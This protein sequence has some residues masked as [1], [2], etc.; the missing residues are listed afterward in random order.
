MCT[1]IQSRLFEMAGTSLSIH[2]RGSRRQG[3]TDRQQAYL[4]FMG[5]KFATF[6][7]N[8]HASPTGALPFLLPTASDSPNESP[9]PSNK[10]QQW[11]LKK[12]SLREEPSNMRYQVYM[13]LLDHRIR[14]AW[15]RL[16]KSY[17]THTAK[18]E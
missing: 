18:S 10:L 6:P 5:I 2:I 9:I 8:N 13:S 16:P 14:L 4:K 7:S 3:F 17:V 12:S 1:F 15:V 11:A